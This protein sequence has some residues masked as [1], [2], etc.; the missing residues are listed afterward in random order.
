MQVIVNKEQKD[1]TVS[2]EGNDYI[3]SAGKPAQVEDNVYEYLKELLPL[4]FDFKPDLKKIKTVSE[5]HKEP[6]KV[7][8]P[9][10]KFG[11]Q[12]AN[13]TRVN[14]PNQN[15]EETPASGKV[16][17]DGIEWTGDGLTNDNL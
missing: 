9:G 3:F 10:G 8:F 17:K 2:F 11:I 7:V 16:D 1:L 12:S 14:F 13:L 4:A 5:V 15:V 6:T